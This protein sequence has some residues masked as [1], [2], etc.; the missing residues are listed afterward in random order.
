MSEVLPLP[1]RGGGGGTP[2]PPFR[3][4]RTTFRRGALDFK[5]MGPM[6]MPMGPYRHLHPVVCEQAGTCHEYPQLYLLS[7]TRCLDNF[8]LWRLHALLNNLQTDVKTLIIF[9]CF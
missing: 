9:S 4:G 3:S 8:V 6:A 5:S 1:K 7:L 2:F